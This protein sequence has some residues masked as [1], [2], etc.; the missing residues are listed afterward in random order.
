MS[1]DDSSKML[2]DRFRDGDSRAAREVFDRYVSR[3]L[4][5]V[6]HRISSKLQ[7]RVDAEDIVQSAMRSFFV[8]A[9][10]DDYVLQRAGDLWRLLAA[11]TLSKLRRQ[12]EVHTAAKR[13]VSTEASGIDS[14][15]YLLAI[16]NREPQPDEEVALLDELTQV[17]QAIE[18]TE[19]EAL[20]L[21]LAGET[22][23]SIALT[24]GR[25]Q[26]TV[27]RLLQT[28]RQMLEQRLTAPQD[29]MT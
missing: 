21:R 15:D 16:A 26:R 23:E 2:F 22:I 18:P 12:V 27:R 24:M 1:S 9:A 8:R 11:I 14:S 19:R 10:N 7:Q 3:L 6:R 13:D 4:S 17:L 28:S 20:Q 25:S 5:L 29:E